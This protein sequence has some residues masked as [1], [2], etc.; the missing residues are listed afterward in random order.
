VNFII[1]HFGSF[2]DDWRVNQQV[3]DQLVRYPN[4]YADTSGVRRFDYIVQAVK[5][6]GAQK[7]LF[8]SDG[9]W[10]HPG[11]ELHKIQLLGLPSDQE[12]LILGGNALQLLRQVRVGKID[13]ERAWEIK[14]SSARPDDDGRN[15][16]A[17]AIDRRLPPPIELEHEL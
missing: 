6:A 2:G 11:L 14:R 3:V 1:P 16:V 5:R 15:R 10:L 12:G 8:G 4:V 13:T 9:P 7:I 17:V